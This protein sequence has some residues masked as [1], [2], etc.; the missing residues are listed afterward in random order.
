MREIVHKAFW[1]SFQEDMSKDPPEYSHVI[2]LLAELKEVYNNYI[3]NDQGMYR[4]VT[5][6]SSLEQDI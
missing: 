2:K 1:D 3:E 6:I 5:F 4:N